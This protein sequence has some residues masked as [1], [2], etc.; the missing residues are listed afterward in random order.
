[1][2]QTRVNVLRLY[3]RGDPA[4]T[5]IVCANVR[6]IAKEMYYAFSAGVVRT[7]HVRRL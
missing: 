6:E 1:M 4:F 3:Y 5:M 2:V 7:M